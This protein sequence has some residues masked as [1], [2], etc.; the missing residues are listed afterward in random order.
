MVEMWI[1]HE[2]VMI[3]LD[4]TVS[5]SA[6]IRDMCANAM[7]TLWRKAA[8]HYCG[9]G[10]QSGVIE[11]SFALHRSWSSDPSLSCELGVLENILC[12]GS[13]C[14]SRVAEYT[15]NEEDAK[16]PRC[17]HPNTDPLQVYWGCPSNVEI[18]DPALA[19]TQG[20]IPLAYHQA[21][22]HPCF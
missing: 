11:K 4:F 14:P 22:S 20:L 3:V 1:D 7:F 16:C 19:A 8:G 9:G 18:D 15:K 6:F 17:G 13:W 10:L 21:A 5:C 2:G 12:G